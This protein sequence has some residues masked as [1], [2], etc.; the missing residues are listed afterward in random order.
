MDSSPPIFG[1]AVLPDARE[2][3]NRV[4]KGV[5]KEFSSEIALFLVKKGSY[6]T[7]NR[8]KIPIRESGKRKGK[9]GKP[10]R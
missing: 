1:E 4:E 7:F 2:S 3:T 9:S 8:V 6:T 5:V 10:G